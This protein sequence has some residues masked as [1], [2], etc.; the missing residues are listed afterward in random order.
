MPIIN[1]NNTKPMILSFKLEDPLIRPEFVGYTPFHM[2][3]KNGTR[4]RLCSIFDVDKVIVSGPATIVMWSDG[5][6]TVVKCAEGELWDEEKAF[7]LCIAKKALGNKGNYYN[8]I[9][10]MYDAW[11]Y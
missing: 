7:A 8:K 1:S 11:K 3:F 10:E 2:E 9:R 6:K 5:T 4:L